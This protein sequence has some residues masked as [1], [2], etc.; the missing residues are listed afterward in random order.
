MERGRRG[1]TGTRQSSERTQ[2]AARRTAGGGDLATALGAQKQRVLAAL[3]EAETLE[4]TPIVRDDEAFTP[5]GYETLVYE[6]HH[7]HL[8]ELEA[9]G[10]VRF[11]RR[12]DEVRRGPRFDERRAVLEDG[13][14]LDRRLRD[15]TRETR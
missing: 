10:Q 4:A 3:E 8:T 5:E 15:R 9:A 12:A 6:H 2:L 13:D 14:R 7:V 11:D 1:E